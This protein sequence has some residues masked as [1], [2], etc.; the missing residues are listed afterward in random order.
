[1][2]KFDNTY[3]WV[4]STFASKGRRAHYA[5]NY[6]HSWRA[7]CGVRMASAEP[8]NLQQDKDTVSKC[9]TC[10]AKGP[11]ETLR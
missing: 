8:L 4:V 2:I 1:M 3:F 9:Q 11:P 10:L 5:K 6:P 7:A